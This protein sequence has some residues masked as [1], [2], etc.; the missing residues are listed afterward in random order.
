ML[1]EDF[2]REARSFQPGPPRPQLLQLVAYQEAR[3]PENEEG[4]DQNAAFRSSVLKA[5]SKK[6][7]QEDR[8]LI[9]FLLEQEIVYHENAWGI[10][11]SIRFCGALLFLLAQ[12]EDVC[13]LWEA[14]TV[15]FDTM[16]GFDVQFLVGAGVAPTLAYLQHIKEEW[17]EDARIYLEECQQAGDFQN[18]ERYREGLRASLPEPA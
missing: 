5:L 9:R 7:S 17:A 2:V 6:F 12:V 16:C 13:L 1:A 15:N 14:K 3:L 10:F 8:P 11:E 18:L 4:D